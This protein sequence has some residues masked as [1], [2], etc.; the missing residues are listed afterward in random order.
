M[1]QVRGIGGI[2]FKSGNPE[3][4]YAW[5]EQH[6]GIAG[7]PGQGAFFPWRAADNTGKEEMTVW[8]IFPESTKYMKDSKANF[9]VNY[10]VDDLDALLAELKAAGVTVDEHVERHDYG[11]FGWITDPDGNRIEL[12]EPKG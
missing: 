9:M 10:I 8:S 3:S 6:L 7:K 12:W 5:Y 2:F 1:A 11:N 4:L